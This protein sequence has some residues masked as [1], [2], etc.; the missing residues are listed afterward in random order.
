M[1]ETWEIDTANNKA[2]CGDVTVTYYDLPDGGFSLNMINAPDVST[3]ERLEL[4]A[5]AARAIAERLQSKA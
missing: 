1:T 3:R 2:V 5:S 4:A